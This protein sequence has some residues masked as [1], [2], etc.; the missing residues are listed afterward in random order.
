MVMFIWTEQEH[1]NHPFF[2]LRLLLLQITAFSA[3]YSKV[4]GMHNAHCTLHKLHIRAMIFFEIKSYYLCKV[5]SNYRNG[6]DWVLWTNYTS[7]CSY[8]GKL[9]AR[10]RKM[11]TKHTANSKLICHSRYDHIDEIAIC[12]HSYICIQV[13]IWLV[14]YIGWEVRRLQ[15]GTANVNHFHSEWVIS[16]SLRF[17]FAQTLS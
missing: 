6:F 16:I 15:H 14:L 13:H 8:F 10:K 12:R 17:Y 4:W 11:C 2:S 7:Y 5:K 1:L 9:C 3:I